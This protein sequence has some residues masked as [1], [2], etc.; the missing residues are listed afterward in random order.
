MPDSKDDFPSTRGR[1]REEESAWRAGTPS[2]PEPEQTASGGYARWLALALLVIV[3][4]QASKYAI[5]GHFAMG[6]TRSIT[7]FFNLTLAYNP[8][9]AF[10][11][12]HDAGGWQRWLFVALGIAAS[13]WIII[14]LRKHGGQKLFSLAL[15]LIMGGALGNVID[16]FTHGGYV[17]DFLD[18]HWG[19]HHFPA[20]NLADSA[21]T[22]GAA[23]MLL[24][25]LL[26]HR[27]ARRAA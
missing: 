9:A 26:E 3:L 10:S 18:F 14:L 19:L 11:M 20:F 15:A 22:C 5:L 25:A 17:V 8:G 6:E 27:R 16:R 21:I 12:L 7:S 2:Q 24:E 1:A 13:T 23:L 4:D